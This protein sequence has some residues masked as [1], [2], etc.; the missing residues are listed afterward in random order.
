[1]DRSSACRCGHCKKLQPEWEKAAQEAQDKVRFGVVDCTN[2]PQL[3]STYGIQ[4]YPTIKVFLPGEK[5]PK[6]YPGGR[7]ASDIVQYINS[8]LDSGQFMLYSLIPNGV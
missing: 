3:A 8:E 5:E 1:M 7:T 2:Q 6:D 4:G